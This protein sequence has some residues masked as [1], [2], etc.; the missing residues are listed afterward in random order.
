MPAAKPKPRQ[1][2]KAK[3]KTP[4]TDVVIP[5]GS[6]ETTWARAQALRI[7]GMTWPTIAQTLGVST[8]SLHAMNHRRSSA[9]GRVVL[10]PVEHRRELIAAGWQ[11]IA[12]ALKNQDAKGL[13]ALLREVARLGGVTPPPQITSNTQVNLPGAIYIVSDSDAEAPAASAMRLPSPKGEQGVAPLSGNAVA[14]E[15]TLADE[16]TS[17]PGARSSDDETSDATSR[18]G[19]RSSTHEEDNDDGDDGGYYDGR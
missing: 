5:P 7:T 19:A 8:Q 9:I 17:R 15:T 14:I 6:P 13:A 16:P 3:R 4:A 12:D 2:I 11:G 18:P 10:D 1:T